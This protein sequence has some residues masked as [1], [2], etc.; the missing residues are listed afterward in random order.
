MSSA[1]PLASARK[2]PADSSN[3]PLIPESYIDAPSQRLYILSIGLLCQVRPILTQ[4]IKSWLTGTKYR[5]SKFLTGSIVLYL[6]RL[7]T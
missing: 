5:Q 2:P 4:K 3:E 7:Q 1:S 6:K